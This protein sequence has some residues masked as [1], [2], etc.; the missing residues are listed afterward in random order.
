MYHYVR[1]L[2]RTKFPRIKGMLV[3]DFKAQVVRLTEGYEMASLSAALSFLN[4]AYQPRRDLCLL[5]FD[6]G[7]EIT[8]LQVTE[9]I[10]DYKIEG[11][12]PIRGSIQVLC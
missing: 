7:L 6:D 8:G 4:G 1:D 10:L 12:M 2:P 11:F 9:V 5:T 3:D